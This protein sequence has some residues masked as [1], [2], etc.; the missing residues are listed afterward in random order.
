LVTI[1]SSKAVRAARQGRRQDEVSEN[2]RTLALVRKYREQFP[3]DI[4]FPQAEC[5]LAM[6]QGDYARAEAVAR[7]VEE[8][9]PA[10][11]RG[12]LLRARVSRAQGL[13]ERGIHAYRGARARHPR[14]DD[15]RMTLG[16]L[17]LDVGGAD[18]SLGEAARILDRSPNQPDALL[19]RASALAS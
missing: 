12:L 17:L 14:R 6:R 18:E 13:G 4:R 1:V 5:E 10:A 19:L 2:A 3:E 8:I 7:Q 15:I 9:S 11:P 16:Q